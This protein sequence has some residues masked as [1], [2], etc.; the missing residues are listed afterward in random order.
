MATHSNIL[1]QNIPWTEKLGRLQSTRLQRVEHN[2][3]TEHP[4]ST[5]SYYKFLAIFPLLYIHPWAYL[6][7]NSLDRLWVWLLSCFSL[8]WLFA[9]L[10]TVASQA[11]LSMGRSKQEYWNRLPYPSPV[12][13]P[14]PGIEP[15]SPG[16]PAL[17]ADSFTHWATW[18]ALGYTKLCILND[19][20]VIFGVV[21]V[22]N[23]SS[24]NNDNY[25]VSLT[26]SY[27]NRRSFSCRF[28]RP[29]T[30]LLFYLYVYF[31]FFFSWFILFILFLFLFFI[32]SFALFVYCDVFS[33]LGSY[34]RFCEI[35]C[36]ILQGSVGLLAEGLSVSPVSLII[37]HSLYSAFMN[38]TFPESKSQIQAVGN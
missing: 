35:T 22:N 7:P 21:N 19:V 15:V 4:H 9:T 16:S 20:A 2:W 36:D 31:S 37:G 5:Y 14:H 26:L 27:T 29:L 10:W 28:L 38:S 33:F 25:S 12:D 23:N 11:P 24:S 1:A 13:L 18:K 17:Q 8:V 32:F 30:T 3:V 6:T 34:L